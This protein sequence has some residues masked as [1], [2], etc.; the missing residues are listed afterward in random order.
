L[1]LSAVPVVKH[2]SHLPV[3][4]DPSHATGKWSLVAPLSKA[5]V[6]CGADG[7]LVEVHPNPEEAL[8]DGSQQLLP[9]NFSQLMREV[10]EIAHVLGRSI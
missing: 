4:V 5:A 3:I 6:A 9:E 8:S 10:K 7:L 1:D 2:L